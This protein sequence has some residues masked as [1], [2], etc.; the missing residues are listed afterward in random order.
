M[1]LCAFG[2][3]GCEVGGIIID[4]TSAKG[5]NWQDNLAQ[6]H[7][8]ACRTAAGEVNI[9]ITLYVYKFYSLG[10]FNT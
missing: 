8:K 2:V 9:H 3:R 10:A 6:T 5:Q 1:G 7:T 4:V